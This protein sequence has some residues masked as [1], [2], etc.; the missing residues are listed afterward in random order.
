MPLAEAVRAPE[1]KSVNDVILA[2]TK[3]FTKNNRITVGGILK[4]LDQGGF[5]ELREREFTLAF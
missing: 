2:L 3:W 5:G 4:S 1:P